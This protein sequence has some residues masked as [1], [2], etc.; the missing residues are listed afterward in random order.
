[1]QNKSH[2]VKTNHYWRKIALADQTFSKISLAQLG[3]EEIEKACDAV[4]QLTSIII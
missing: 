4:S 1:M 2:A 3:R